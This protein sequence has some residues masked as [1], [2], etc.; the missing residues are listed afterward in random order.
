MV[1]GVCQIRARLAATPVGIEVFADREMA[2]GSV[3]V[4]DYGDITNSVFLH[5]LGFQPAHNP[6]D[7]VSLPVPALTVPRL[8][9]NG[10]LV[11]VRRLV[12]QRCNGCCGRAPF[13]TSVGC[14]T[15]GVLSV[16]CA[17]P[18]FAVWRW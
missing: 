17:V 8:S 10:S 16:L 15:S 4:E 6:F 2:A 5:H 18:G 7:C 12:A 1:L 14:N 3:V 11:E 13:W 9:A